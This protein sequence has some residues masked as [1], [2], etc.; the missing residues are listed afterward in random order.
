MDWKKYTPSGCRWTK[1]FSSGSGT[2][3]VEFQL[4]YKWDNPDKS[5]RTIKFYTKLVLYEYAYYLQVNSAGATRENQQTGY[6]MKIGI[7]GNTMVN[8]ISS[9]QE[10]P[11]WGQ[12]SY[13]S[14]TLD[15]CST[16][17][18]LSYKDDGTVNA[19]I[20]YDLYMKWYSINQG[21]I[22]SID[23]KGSYKVTDIPKIDTTGITAI[24]FSS[25][26]ITNEIS[27]NKIIYT[28]ID[29]SKTQI[30]DAG[31]SIILKASI[32]GYSTKDKVVN[33][34][35]KP[36]NAKGNITIT[37]SNTQVAVPKTNT[38]D[39]T[40]YKSFTLS[41]KQPGT[42][43]I[44]AKS[45]S[46][47]STTLKCTVTA[48]KNIAWSSSNTSV[49]TINNG[50]VNAKNNING[51]TTIKALAVSNTLASNSVVTNV[52]LPPNRI[53]VTTNKSE[54]YP[55]E[56]I[57][58]SV[59]L[60]PYS[61]EN[62]AMRVASNR[63][64]TNYEI[65]AITRGHA[66]D[67]TLNNGTR[68][69]MK[70]NLNY[71]FDNYS[72]PTEYIMF[73]ANSTYNNTIT[74]NVSIPVKAPTLD[75]DKT[76][77]QVVKGGNRDR[78]ITVTT[79]PANST[80]NYTYDS[81]YITVTKSGN[82][83]NVKGVNDI[84]STPIVVTGTMPIINSIMQAPTK[85]VNVKVGSAPITNLKVTPNPLAYDIG[86]ANVAFTDDLE[87]YYSEETIKKS[88]YNAYDNGSYQINTIVGLSPKTVEFTI[89]YEPLN[90]SDTIY[91]T[92]N[93]E[94]IVSVPNEYKEIYTGNGTGNGQVKA[95]IV[96]NRVGSTYLT[97]TSD[98]SSINTII[99]VNCT[100]NSNVIVTSQNNALM[101][102]SNNYV[103]QS[104]SGLGKQ[105]VA[106]TNGF[107]GATTVTVKSA[108]DNTKSYTLPFNCWLRPSA[109]E[110]T[111]D[112][113]K[114]FMGD[115][116]NLNVL[117]KPYNPNSKA[118]TVADELSE[119]EYKFITEQGTVF[120]Q[121]TTIRKFN[122][123]ISYEVPKLP[124][125]S[126]EQC[127]YFIIE[128]SS[129]QRPSIK[130]EIKI[131]FKRQGVTI[132]GSDDDI[133]LYLA[134]TENSFKEF[135][136]TVEPPTASY[137]I[138]FNKPSIT[139]KDGITIQL[140]DND[141]SYLKISGSNYR[142]LTV[143][144]RPA[145]K[146]ETAHPPQN[147]QV[148]NVKGVDLTLKYNEPVVYGTPTDVN[149]SVFTSQ[150]FD[151]PK[152]INAVP[153]MSLPNLYT[154]NYCGDKPKFF[155]QLPTKND[156]TILKNIY[157]TFSN[158]VTYVVNR[159]ELYPNSNAN[160][161][162]AAYSPNK[163]NHDML[164]SMIVDYVYPKDSEN[165]TPY[166][167]FVP[168]NN[169]P[170]GNVKITY[171]SKFP[172]TIPN[173]TIMVNINK[174][175]L[176]NLPEVG[177]LIKLSD[178]RTF[179]SVVENVLAPYYNGKNDLFIK[180]DI[181]EVLYGISASNI[182]SVGQVGERIN[183]M[184]FFKILFALYNTIN[185]LSEAINVIGY[186]RIPQYLDYVKPRLMLVTDKN[187]LEW[188]NTYIKSLK[189]PLDNELYND[190][191]NLFGKD[192]LAHI[193]NENYPIMADDS[194]DYVGS[195]DKEIPNIYKTTDLYSQYTISPISEIIKALKQ[196]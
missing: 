49:A 176:P 12:A 187:R 152:I 15:L 164:T 44:T 20:D 139:E 142:N 43:T 5:K 84:D 88:Q 52:L 144:D 73:K 115:I 184:P 165:G 90:A 10:D 141:N 180:K 170:N 162:S 7:S 26:S 17:R 16:S 193:T 21:S 59:I 192:L 35:V 111:T 92:S 177:S 161:F 166:T 40:K 109:I 103:S 68:N 174:K 96:C 171:V 79:V 37:S 4:W 55:G 154:L 138:E 112:K 28:N 30:V 133:K 130:D 57:S 36:T 168:S 65:D 150:Y 127:E 23:A 56:T 128:V 137:I 118:E 67:K 2:C 158:G 98:D 89:N 42:T 38:I 120:E 108:I 80:F 125:F 53:N 186:N 181:S 64:G 129:V 119:L 116:I 32:D 196:L 188:Y 69:D 195:P 87:N 34:S 173:A 66:S 9:I 146:L 50:T 74:A 183:A 82:T 51:T 159:D 107:N 175:K 153:D 114:V 167:T 47:K 124:L 145:T 95:K 25:N 19:T 126:D 14:H 160:N 182:S 105:Y 60:E 70:Y 62:S 157:I 8:A 6:T 122:N 100:A 3:V 22:K 189:R 48:N 134:T 178:I 156:F 101:R 13:G 75:V 41:L 117:L 93:D 97:L 110:I 94:S 135:N 78:T 33:F 18:T 86:I 132:D 191:N 149:I 163:H 54:I 39:V 46:N 121:F 77:L 151:Y 71:T 140:K 136:V 147:P 131:Y 190:Y 172:E 29:S 179:I 106:Y 1:P 99:Y 169:V 72:L 24:T 91:M 113:T 185:H 143:D 148:V 194:N 58:Y 104:N 76:S 81:N 85:T 45:D 63:R 61:A 102:V 155:F 83:L 31:K 11:K 27:P 123:S